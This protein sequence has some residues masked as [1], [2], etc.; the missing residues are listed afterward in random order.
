MSFTSQIVRIGEGWEDSSPV[1]EETASYAIHQKDV[2][3][4]GAEGSFDDFKQHFPDTYVDMV[5]EAETASEAPVL[6]TPKKKRKS[7]FSPRRHQKKFYN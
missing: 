7:V 3:G 6:P 5:K 1:Q 4:V 2:L